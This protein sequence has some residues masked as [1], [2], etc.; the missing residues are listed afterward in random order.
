MEVESSSKNTNTSM[1]VLSV[2]SRRAAS[3]SSK[4]LWVRSRMVAGS[5]FE[6]AHAATRVSVVTITKMVM[7]NGRVRSE[8][9]GSHYHEK[10]AAMYINS[11]SAE[12]LV[13]QT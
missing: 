8:I 4:S 6:V 2:N 7:R 3:G 11:R 10:N 12:N 13:T 1:P 9:T 5:L